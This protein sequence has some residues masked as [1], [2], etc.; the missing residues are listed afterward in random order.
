VAVPLFLFFTLGAAGCFSV[1]PGA[2]LGV[3]RGA[4]EASAIWQ[5]LRSTGASRLL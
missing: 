1:C 3:F 2:F 4:G 5:T